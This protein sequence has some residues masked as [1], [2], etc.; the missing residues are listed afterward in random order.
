MDI[1]GKHFKPHSSGITTVDEVEILALETLR[2]LPYLDDEYKEEI[3]RHIQIRKDHYIPPAIAPYVDA[4]LCAQI[5]DSFL[6]Y[7]SA[8]EKPN[9]MS[10]VDYLY[11]H[12]IALIPEMV[13]AKATIQMLLMDPAVITDEECIVAITELPETPMISTTSAHKAAE[14]LKKLQVLLDPRFINTHAAIAIR[15]KNYTAA[16]YNPED[17]PQMDENTVK[18]IKRIYD[19]DVSELTDYELERLIEELDDADAQLFE[20]MDSAK[21][22][23]EKLRKQFMDTYIERGA[24]N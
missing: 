5:R 18:Q 24:E 8:K 13:V 19:K 14:F 22:Y 17:I 10:A 1:I 9:I 11:Q 16:S 6:E 4:A 2:E 12:Y 7:T 23:I 20:G 3:D 21:A 15:V